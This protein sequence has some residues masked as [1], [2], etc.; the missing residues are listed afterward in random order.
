MLTRGRI[1]VRLMAAAACAVAVQAGVLARACGVAS[2]LGTGTRTFTDAAQHVDWCERRWPCC[3][4]IAG[5]VNPRYS[6]NGCRMIVR[7]GHMT[8]VP[9]SVLWLSSPMEARDVPC[10]AVRQVPH[11]HDDE[12][13]YYSRQARG[14]VVQVA[15]AGVPWRGVTL[16]RVTGK[17]GVSALD[18]P[19]VLGWTLVELRAWPVV[20]DVLVLVGLYGAV[21]AERWRRGRGCC[22]WCGYSLAGLVSGVCPECGEATPP[23]V[24]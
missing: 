22:R 7:N 4:G 15:S 3:W 20:A 11:G 21:L 23:R 16:A 1:A 9:A 17:P 14:A 12:Y 24:E 6:L 19:S 8:S 2:G 13:E 10:R 5:T 18:G